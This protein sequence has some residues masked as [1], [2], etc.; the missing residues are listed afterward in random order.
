M[1][2][3]QVLVLD[4]SVAVKWYVIEDQRD[5]A[6]KL[7]QDYMDGK[8]DLVTPSLILYEV[9][10]AIRYHPGA[11]GSDVEEAIKGLREME[12]AIQDLTDAV[13]KVAANIAFIEDVTFHDATYLAI[14]ESLNTKLITADE[15]LY[16]QIKER[17][18]RILLLKNYQ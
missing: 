11:M 14:A 13:I 3:A 10:N 5:K 16:E 7:R 15:K 18:G 8:I 17:R 9:G 12:I 2:G 4:A 6:L 1:E